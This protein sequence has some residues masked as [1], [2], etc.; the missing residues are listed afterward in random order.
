[1]VTLAIWLRA[2]IWTLETN[3]CADIRSLIARADIMAEHTTDLGER[4]ARLEVCEVCGLGEPY[5]G[6]D[7]ACALAP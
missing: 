5:C 1:M 3:G 2:D 6:T 4:V 7:P